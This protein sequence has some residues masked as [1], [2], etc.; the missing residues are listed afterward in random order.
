M[1]FSNLSISN[2]LASGLVSITFRQLSQRE[3]VDLVKNAGL[4]SIEWGGD[5]HAPHGDVA[6]ARLVKSLTVDAGLKTAAYGSYYRAGPGDPSLFDKVLQSAVELD[7]P[8]IRVW[9]GGK[10]SAETTD[11][12]RDDIAADLRRIAGLAASANIKIA[13]EYHGGTLTDNVASAKAVLDSTAAAN[14]RTLW[15]P[16]N[17]RN[18]D[19]HIAEIETLAPYLENVHCF[20]WHDYKNRYPL[21]DGKDQWRSYLSAIKKL[22]RPT[23]VLIEFVKDDSPDQFLADASALKSWLQPD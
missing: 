16:A 23:A 9:A 2:N 4:D 17:D 1:T 19:M 12:E 6:A 5:V 11:E 7:A 14:V 20:H 21:S 13:L 15:Q 8:V 18:V 22:N 10:G 3:I